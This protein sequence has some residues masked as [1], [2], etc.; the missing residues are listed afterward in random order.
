MADLSETDILTVNELH[1]YLK[2]PRPPL[3]PLAQTGRIPAAK[4]GKHWRFRK[5]EIDQWL[6]AQRWARPLQ[7]RAKA[8]TPTVSTNYVSQQS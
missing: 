8:K 4:I 3:Y 2:I 7:R 5:A 1:A 6:T